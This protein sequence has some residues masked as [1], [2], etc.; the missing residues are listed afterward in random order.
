ME[1]QNA[2]YVDIAPLISFRILFGLLM[3]VGGIRFWYEG[4]IV[5][6]FVEPKLFFKYYGFEW[7]EVPSEMGLYA[8]FLVMIVSALCIAFGFIY[9]VMSVLFFCSFTYIELLDATN[10]L[11]HYYL[12]ICFAFLLIFL[13]ANSAFSLDVKFSWVKQRKWIP[14]WNIDVLKAQLLLVYTCAGIAKLNSDWLFQGMPM[15]VWLP[16][17]SEMPLLGILFG[18]KGMPLF[19]SWCGA[20]YDLSIA[21]FLLFSRTRTIAY[22]FVVVFHLMTFMMFNIG[23]FP[24]IMIFLTTIFFEG[25]THRKVLQKIGFNSSNN[26][27]KQPSHTAQ[28][29]N[30]L[31]PERTVRRYDR[32]VQ[33]SKNFNNR[34]TTKAVVLIFILIQ[35]LMPFRHWLYKGDVLWT[36]E[37]YRFSWRVMVV[38]KNGQA[39]FSVSDPE[40]GRTS[41]IINGQYL[42]LFQE[43]QMAIQPD[44]M[45]QFAH[46]L[47]Q[48]FQEKYSIENPVVKVQ[49]SVA[50]NGRSSRTFANPNVDLSKQQMSLK[51]YDWIDL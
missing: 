51:H 19:F 18:I 45:I 12:I 13:P 39:I 26:F 40:T 37:G 47:D 10:Y 11:N 9:R 1:I 43:K 31:Y 30:L 7:V 20:I 6:L 38:E 28:K 25:Q 3:A 46:F 23:L 21:W 36:E 15:A 4:W 8:L 42:T 2:K 49:S 5:K 35:F 32:G 29:P 33:A 48:E 34:P 17:R 14:R 24:F 50:L 41:E 27:D 44:M 22:F 16:E